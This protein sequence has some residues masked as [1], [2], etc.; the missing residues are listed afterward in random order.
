MELMQLFDIMLH[1]DSPFHKFIL[2]K[3]GKVKHYVFLCKDDNYLDKI[4]H[5][6]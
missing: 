6:I 2:I 3:S 1:N 4:N 5:E